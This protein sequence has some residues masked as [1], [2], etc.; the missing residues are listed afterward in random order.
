M[1]LERSTT[2]TVVTSAALDAALVL[3]FVLIGRASHNEGIAGVLTTWWPFLGGL[4]IGW[5]LARAWR[6]PNALVWT[7]LVVWLF[8]V[9]GGLALRVLVGQ[10]V[11]LSF[12]IVTTLVLG[13]FLLGWRAIWLL[14]RRAR[15]RSRAAS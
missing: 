4:A 12:A 5:M 6:R 7:G 1:A 3:L 10:G 15:R 9:V 11:Q 2:A 13:F 8:T 14:I